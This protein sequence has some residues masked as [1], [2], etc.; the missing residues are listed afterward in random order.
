MPIDSGEPA[1][2][3]ADLNAALDALADESRP[4]IPVPAPEQ[5]AFAAFYHS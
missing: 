1:A 2:A 5:Q 3:A 4:T